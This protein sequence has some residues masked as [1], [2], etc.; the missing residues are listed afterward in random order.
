M[1]SVTG[2][3]VRGVWSCRLE[4]G[5]DLRDGSKPGRML[6]GEERGCPEVG[7][8]VGCLIRHMALHRI[9]HTG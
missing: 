5:L 2:K 3:Y 9:I 1:V 8:M 7:H 4:E 6:G